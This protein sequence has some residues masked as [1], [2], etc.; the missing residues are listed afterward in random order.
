MPAF[1][2]FSLLFHSNR[3]LYRIT[4]LLFKE[5]HKVEYKKIVSEHLF[6]L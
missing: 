2:I 6:F 4:P 1:E 3:Y 5:C